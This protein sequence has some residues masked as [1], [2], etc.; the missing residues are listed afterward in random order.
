[1]KVYKYILL[2]V[3]VLICV[4]WISKN[5]GRYEPYAALATLIFSLVTL[6]ENDTKVLSTFW[7]VHTKKG[8]IEVKKEWNKLLSTTSNTDV[9]IIRGARLFDRVNGDFYLPSSDT[10]T[11]LRVLM[12]ELK[13]I[14]GFVGI[15]EVHS[16]ARFVPLAYV[17][18]S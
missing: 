18:A 14:A 17:K 5:D 11:N 10:R 12:S 15:I 1:M 13:K 7:N 3:S 6:I 16:G 2:I 8:E 4:F 9:F